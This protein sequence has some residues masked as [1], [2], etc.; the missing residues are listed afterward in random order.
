MDH[1]VPAHFPLSSPPLPYVAF[2]GFFCHEL[3]S[4]SW[5]AFE[6]TLSCWP[7]HHTRV[8]ASCTADAPRQQES[9]CAKRGAGD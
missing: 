8:K 5:E 4:R 3:V 1:E 2:S 9:S 7:W 6:D